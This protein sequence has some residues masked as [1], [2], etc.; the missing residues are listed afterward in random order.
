MLGVWQQKTID[1]IEHTLDRHE[2]ATEAFTQ[3]S[4]KDTGYWVMAQ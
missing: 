1:P 3:L 4:A 2:P